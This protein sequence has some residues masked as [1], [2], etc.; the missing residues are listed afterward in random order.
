MLPMP[1]KRMKFKGNRVFVE[2][3]NHGELIVVDGR[4]QMK[5]R[6]EDTRVY[7]P[8][9]KNLT[10]MEDSDDSPGRPQ[11]TEKQ[12]VNRGKSNPEG[13]TKGATKGTARR[14]ATVA[15]DTIIA[16]TDGACSGNPGPAGLGYV[17]V[18]PGGKRIQQGEPMGMATNNIA[19]LTA[20]LRVLEL[21]DNPLSSI[22]I[23][24]DS[25]YSIGV[26]SQGWKAKA[27]KELIFKIKQRLSNM[28]NVA[29]KKV[30]GH[31][32]VPENELVDDLARHASETQKNVDE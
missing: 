11:T 3:N 19:E 5:Y 28:P 22:V 27:N 12:A 26:L 32:G 15:D 1:F 2:V 8:S 13:T 6:L 14:A 4:A 30:K 31:A 17:I 20:I 9:P 18:F 25:A 21:V 29:L 24:T 7:T 23:H 10:E 16:Y